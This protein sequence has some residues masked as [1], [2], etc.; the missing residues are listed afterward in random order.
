MSLFFGKTDPVDQADR[1]ARAAAD[2]ESLAKQTG[3]RN[4]LPAEHGSRLE[5]AAGAI[6]DEVYKGRL[7]QFSILRAREQAL[8]ILQQAV[9]RNQMSEDVALQD[10]REACQLELEK[11]LDAPTAAAALCRARVRAIVP[12]PRDQFTWTWESAVA[13]ALGSGAIPRDI[14][15]IAIDTLGAEVLKEGDQIRAFD[16]RY[17][18]VFYVVGTD[19]KTREVKYSSLQEFRPRGVVMSPEGIARWNLRFKRS[20]QPESLEGPAV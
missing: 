13:R 3:L 10:Y 18:G 9:H 11:W 20:H 4:A 2:K 15:P 17:G 8:G 6:E 19:N 7:D 5:M 14:P 12:K 1:A 16:E